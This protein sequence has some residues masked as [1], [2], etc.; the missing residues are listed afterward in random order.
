MSPAVIILRAYINRRI[1]RC[2]SASSTHHTLPNGF[3]DWASSAA[4][5]RWAE[6]S[7]PRDGDVMPHCRC[8]KLHA[9]FLFRMA[10]MM[11]RS[12]RTAPASVKEIE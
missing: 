10:S 8:D 6:L 3:I 7:L 11:V 5:C 9:A 4:R 12:R 2:R 1:K